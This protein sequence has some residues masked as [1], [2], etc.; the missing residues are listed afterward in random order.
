MFNA[1]PDQSSRFDNF[2]M[3]V[4][5]AAPGA[6]GGLL[7]QAQTM[8]PSKAPS[9]LLLHS[10][11]RL[12][13]EKPNTE[14]VVRTFSSTRPACQEVE[15][16]KSSYYQNPDPAT[17]H[18]PRLERKLVR[19]GS[20]PIG[21][22]RRRAALA[23]SPGVPFDE[24]P[25]QCFQEARKILIADRAEKLKKI[26]TERARI[27]RLQ[28]V[29]PNTFPGGDVYKQRRLRSMAEELEKL[30][31]HADINDPNVKRRFEDGLGMASASSP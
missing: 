24:L 10:L 20:F 9:A 31:I 13:V 5:L 22:R 21:S 16:Q 19:A 29:D 27:A 12:A 1:S 6:D 25:Y 3:Q 8:A 11:R 23:H 7:S 14:G 30:K 2:W 26:E 4:D 15:V 17:V 18:V 28:E